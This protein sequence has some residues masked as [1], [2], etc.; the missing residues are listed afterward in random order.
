MSDGGA[1]VNTDETLQA[2]PPLTSCHEAWF[3]TGHR[4]VPVC[5]LGAG[6]PCPRTLTT[7]ARVRESGGI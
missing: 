4:P 7:W 5:G 1:A 2:H 6:D 3:L